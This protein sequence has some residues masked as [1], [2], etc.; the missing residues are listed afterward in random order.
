MK[1]ESAAAARVLVL[2]LQPGIFFPDGVALSMRR[3]QARRSPGAVMTQLATVAYTVEAPLLL[4][5]RR[6]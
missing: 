1:E 4:G 6:G 3:T 2:G 5:L